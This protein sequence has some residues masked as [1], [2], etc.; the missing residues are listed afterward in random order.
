MY[1]Y[2]DLSVGAHGA[3]AKGVNAPI[4]GVIGS[5][6]MIDVVSGSRLG[7][8]ARPLSALTSEASV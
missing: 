4:G 3:E 2:E 7:F 6:D 1:K 8:S 5:C